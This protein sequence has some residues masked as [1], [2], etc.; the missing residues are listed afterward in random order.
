MPSSFS[1]PLP[2]P[3]FVYSRTCGP[4]VPANLSYL[5]KL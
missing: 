5:P 3:H 4:V 1:A 2:T